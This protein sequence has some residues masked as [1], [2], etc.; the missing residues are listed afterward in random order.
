GDASRAFQNL[1]TTAQL[2]RQRMAV[3]DRTLLL[4]SGLD[5]AYGQTQVLFGVNFEVQEGELVALLGTNGAGKSTLLKAISG[6]LTP[7]GGTTFYDGKD[8]TGTTA[9][10]AAAEG[11][12]IVPGGKGV[13]PG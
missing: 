3:G 10:Q 7:T 8:L 9:P 6:T 13:F 4:C 11:I 5:V 1:V 2:R 12:V